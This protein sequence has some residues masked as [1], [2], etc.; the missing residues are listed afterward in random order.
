MKWD[1]NLY[2]GNSISH[3]KN[4]VKWKIIHN[5]GQLDI[6]VIALASNPSNL[7][8]V[9][10]AWE[11][12]QKS[13]PGK[14][15]KYII[16]LAGSYEEALEVVTTIINEVYSNTGQFQILNYLKK[17]KEDLSCISS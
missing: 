8:D 16:G 1:E 3:K 14:K 15:E 11:L 2:V 5:A 10:P 4:R 13:Y 6:Y 9:I 17:K 12:M 7:L